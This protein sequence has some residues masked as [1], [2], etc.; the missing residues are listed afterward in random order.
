MHIFYAY[1]ISLVKCKIHIG[2]FEL[3]Y[4]NNVT[5]NKKKE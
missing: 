4:R 3:K 2:K 5:V 1:L